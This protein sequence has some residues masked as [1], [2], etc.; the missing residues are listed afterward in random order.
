VKLT[1]AEQEEVRYWRE[2]RRAAELRTRQ[3][4][5]LQKAIASVKA[6]ALDASLRAL[7]RACKAARLDDDR[8]T[9][10]VN[11]VLGSEPLSRE[12]QAAVQKHPHLSAFLDRSRDPERRQ[13]A[14]QARWDAERDR[15][16]EA[17]AYPHG[18]GC[19]CGYCTAS[20]TD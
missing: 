20:M 1:P 14:Q 15:E 5:A 2:Q 12:T 18:R 8:L 9:A 6:A 11:S 17:R 10:L 16:I 7:D 19:T 4:D 3:D 13:A